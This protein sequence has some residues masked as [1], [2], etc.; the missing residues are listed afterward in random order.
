M[1]LYDN[2]AYRDT[3]VQ[4]VYDLLKDDPDNTR[5]N[6]IIELFDN[7]LV[8]SRPSNER[9][10]E[11]TLRKMVGQPV[12]VETE[13]RK[14]WCILWGYHGPE[15]YG[16]AFIF[17]KRT[18]EKIQLPFDGLGVTWFPYLCQPEGEDDG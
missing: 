16:R 1:K 15:V 10:A 4:G 18:A 7:A 3:F 13:K 14:E 6:S 11:E 8:V 5:A 12:W 9:L 2:D 17:T